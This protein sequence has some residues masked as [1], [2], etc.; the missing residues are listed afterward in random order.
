M[1]QCIHSAQEQQEKSVSSMKVSTYV[2]KNSRCLLWLQN[3]NYNENDKQKLETITYGRSC[4]GTI[5]V[6]ERLVPA[7]R[8]T[9]EGLGNDNR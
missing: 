5:P 6:L 3:R 7:R 8:R 4:S 1:L 9:I 2:D